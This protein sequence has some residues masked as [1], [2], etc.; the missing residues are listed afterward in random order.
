MRSQNLEYVGLDQ[1]AAPAS[2]SPSPSPLPSPP[3]PPSPIPSFSASRSPR[4]RLGGSAAAVAGRCAR[5]SVVGAL[6]GCCAQRRWRARRR[7]SC[8]RCSRPRSGGCVPPGRGKGCGARGLARR[9]L[10][11]RWLPSPTALAHPPEGICTVYAWHTVGV[12]TACTLLGSQ[13]E[14]ARRIKMTNELLVPVLR[15]RCAAAVAMHLSTLLLVGLVAQ[16]E[17]NGINSELGTFLVLACA[18]GLRAQCRRAATPPPGTRRPARA[19]T[20]RPFASPWQAAS[21]S[22]SSPRTTCA[23]ARANS[24]SSSC[25]WWSEL[26]L[27]SVR[28]ARRS[29]VLRRGLDKRLDR[30]AS[31]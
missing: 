31:T 16:Y 19:S 25:S 27:S 9:A 17:L 23:A 13:G 12:R 6:S 18:G 20:P 1:V 24:S 10:P 3:P 28:R 29:G 4:V 7:C 11:L 8:C 21:S 2:L 30:R 26:D 22:R 5:R 14:K 15:R